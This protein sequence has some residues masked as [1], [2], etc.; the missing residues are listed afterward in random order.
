M[1][2]ANYIM[3]EITS[4]LSCLDM[5]RLE[6]VIESAGEL[7]LKEASSCDDELWEVFVDALQEK[8]SK[9]ENE[10]FLRVFVEPLDQ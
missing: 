7:F 4:S 10:E 8:L 9:K 2:S 5:K 3:K 1:F 6:L